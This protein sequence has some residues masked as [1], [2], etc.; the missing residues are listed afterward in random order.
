VA[1]AVVKKSSKDGMVVAEITEI[2]KNELS[3]FDKYTIGN[4]YDIKGYYP[5][6]AN[7]AQPDGYLIIV[8]GQKN[9]SEMSFS[10]VGNRLF[11]LAGLSLTKVRSLISDGDT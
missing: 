9:R 5:R 6:A 3:D 2:L 1:I 8:A 10:F 7:S 4:N 11:G